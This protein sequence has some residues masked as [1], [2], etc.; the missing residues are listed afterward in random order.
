MKVTFKDGLAIGF[1]LCA[2][3]LTTFLL[4]FDNTK[5]KQ[6]IKFIHDTVFVAQY[7]GSYYNPVASQC[8]NTPTIT[9][10]GHKI[11]KEDKIVALSRDLLILYPYHSK[12]EVIYPEHLKGIWLVKDCMNKRYK[13]RID[14]L[15]FNK[16]KV[17]KVIL[18]LWWN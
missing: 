1:F 6:N 5:E 12:I 9:S 13:K 15:S 4:Y 2:A 17:D 3:I 16:I 18:K 8:D 14:F 10:I 7:K 11:K